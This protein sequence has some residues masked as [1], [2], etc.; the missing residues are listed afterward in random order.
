M[1]IRLSTNA[2]N[3]MLGGPGLLPTIDVDAGPAKLTL[4]SGPQPATADTAP[5][6]TLLATI[7]LNDPSFAAPVGGN[8][9]MDNT[10]VPTGIGVAAGTAGWARLSDQSGDSVLDGSVSASGGGGDFEIGT[11][12]ISIGLEIP[13]E[14][15]TIT[16]PAQ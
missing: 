8:L 1:T 9:V 4:Y 11:T 15:G 3:S 14:S 16:M 5:T 6:G 12:T 10:P 13:L 7:T 2:R